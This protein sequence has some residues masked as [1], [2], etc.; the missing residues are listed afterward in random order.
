MIIHKQEHGKFTISSLSGSFSYFPF[1]EVIF[2]LSDNFVK[3]YSLFSEYMFII[4]SVS[5]KKRKS[6]IT[7]GIFYVN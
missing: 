1:L 4:I 7:R 2:I 5:E 6:I 3:K